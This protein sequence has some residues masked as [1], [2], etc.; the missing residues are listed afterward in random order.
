MGT[1]EPQIDHKSDTQTA[2]AGVVGGCGLPDGNC[3][4]CLAKSERV[5]SLANQSAAPIGDGKNRPNKSFQP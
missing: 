1:D 5:S 4:E 2:K 3:V